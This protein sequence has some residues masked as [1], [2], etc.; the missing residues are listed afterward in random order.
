M[1]YLKLISLQC[2]DTEDV[3]GADETYLLIAGRRVWGPNS[4]N[5]NDTADLTGM[6]PFRFNRS[7]RIELY[8][9][10]AGWWD[11]DDFLGATFAYLSQ[12]GTGEKEHTFTGDGANYRL[13]YEVI[14]G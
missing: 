5:D 3:T 7:I 1:P 10:D 13:T 4:M 11:D 6:T 2:K 14:R 8:D 9:Q 12:M